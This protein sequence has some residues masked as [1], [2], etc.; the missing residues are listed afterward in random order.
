MVV[1]GLGSNLGDRLGYLRE[2]VRRLSDVMTGLRCSSVYESPAMLPENAPPEWDIAYYN[3]VI[4]GGTSLSPQELL[5]FAKIIEQELG[6]TDRGRWGPREI[7]VDIL[8]YGQKV[9]GEPDL[10]VP[11]AGLLLRDFALVPLA[12]IAPDW[13]HP[14]AVRTAKQLAEAVPTALSRLEVRID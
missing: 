11:H 12:E 5:R 3:M 4:V 6:R 2:A 10:I 14:V 1:L 7:D 9:L 13:V 8:A